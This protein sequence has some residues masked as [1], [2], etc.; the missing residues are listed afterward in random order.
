LD[1]MR[2]ISQQSDSTVPNDNGHARDLE[3]QVENLTNTLTTTQKALLV[4]I[5][6]HDRPC[7][8]D[9]V[10]HACTEFSPQRSAAVPWTAGGT[11]TNRNPIYCLEVTRST[12][13]S[14]SKATEALKLADL[15]SSRVEQ[16]Q[17]NVA[18]LTRSLAAYKEKATTILSDKERV[19]LYPF[20]SLS[21]SF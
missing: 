19:S 8:W 6:I 11:T 1:E 12:E 17:Q 18:R 15:S 7:T 2:T 21:L 20:L 10:L 14:E 4:Y 9:Q 13:E 5:A 3:V 16:L